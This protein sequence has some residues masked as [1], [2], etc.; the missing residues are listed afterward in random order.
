VRGNPIVESGSSRR[1]EPLRLAYLAWVVVCLVWGTTYLAIRV[2]LE[3]I[4]P[5]SLGAIRFIIAGFLLAG[6]LKARGVALPARVHWRG[7]AIVGVLLI[8]VGNGMVVVAEQWVPSGIAA[9][10]IATTPFWM[11]GLEA[12]IPGGERFSRRTL[13]G[14]TI[15]F[16]GILLLLWPDLTAGGSV[17]RQFLY[18]LIALQLAEIGW[19]GGTAYSRRHAREENALAAAALQMIFGGAAMLVMACVGREWA[20]L[21]FTARTAMAELYLIVVGSLIAFPAYI[22]ALKHLPVATVSLYAYINPVIAVLLGALLLGEPFGLRI[23]IAS[24]LVLL[25]VGVVRGWMGKR[26]TARRAAAAL[27]SDVVERA[28]RSF[29]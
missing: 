6:V 4:P 15:G 9:V 10:V 11:A 17:G 20:Y 29:G 13:V 7:M 12:L 28:P 2:A 19:S 1:S 8:G 14:M 3:T 18:G 22:Y 26:A 27:N 25:G 23:V 5:A 24:A 16:A 21:H